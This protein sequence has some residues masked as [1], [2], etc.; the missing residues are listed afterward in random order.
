MLQLC[1]IELE[2][3]M[4][5][6]GA[7]VWGVTDIDKAI[8]FWSQ[9]LDYVPKYPPECDFAILVPR[10]GEGFQLSFNRV[11]SP[12]PAA[13]IWIF[14]PQ[15]RPAKCSACLVW[16]PDENLGITSRMQ[17]MSFWKI[18]MATHFA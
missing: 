2:V 12:H 11:T 14:T 18:Q 5:K 10:Q 4:L 8:I 9:A 13:I 16:E 7:I 15:T 3:N 17:T 6:I 1:D